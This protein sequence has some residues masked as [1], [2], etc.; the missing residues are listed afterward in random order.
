MKLKPEL[1]VVLHV[2]MSDA[3]RRGH[4]FAGLEHLLFALC[5]DPETVDVLR[6]T[7][8]DVE[9]L[10]DRLDAYLQEE[11]EAFGQADEPQPT[12]AFQ[13]VIQ[14]AI[15]HSRSAGKEIVGGPEVLV[16]IFSEPDSHAVTFLGELGV[17]RLDVVSYISHGVTKLDGEDGFP[18]GETG[19]EPGMDDSDD[20]DDTDEPGERRRGGAAPKKDPLEAF[21]VNLNERALAGDIDP[22]IGR[23]R[24]IDRTV[25]IL[26]RRRKNNPLFVGD[27]GVGKT[28]IVE[29]LAR[30]IVEGDVPPSLA[31][32]TIF[33][34]DLGQ[35][36]AG[37]RYRG[38]F[39]SRLKAVLKALKKIPDAILFIDE[40]HTVIGAG[41]ASGST[42]DASNLL[43][44]A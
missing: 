37:T 40:I 35:L 34:L 28:A 10:K 36:L 33:N 24:E 6:N 19:G 20:G 17:T 3:G 22:L 26:A 8:A 27:S 18:L 14:R 29:G 9:S 41:S 11:T 32:V 25:R 4:E 21:C 12:I 7:G 1:E 16:A 5:H 30:R 13:R 38:D 44:P 31:E 2:A 23:Q 15:F 39:E 42:M 43:K